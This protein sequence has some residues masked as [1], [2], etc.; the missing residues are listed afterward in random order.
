MDIKLVKRLCLGTVQFGLDYGIANQRGKISEG[1]VGQILTY[2]HQVGIDTIDTGQAYGDSEHVIGK[3]IEGGMCDFNIIT[4]TPSLNGF[5][6]E[7]NAKNIIQPSLKALGREKIYG[8]LV[9]QFSDYLTH[10]AL[11]GMMEELKR[12]GIVQKIGFSIYKPEELE[13]LFDRNVPFDIIQFPY[14]IFDRR[15]E[16]YFSRLKEKN[17]EINVRSVFLQ[18]L[19]F[20]NPDTL[21]EHLVHARD[22]LK[23]LIDASK[24]I[25]VPVHAVCLN[26]VLLNSDIDIAIIGIDSLE[27]LKQNIDAVKFLSEV[28][29]IYDDIKAISINDESILLPY[30]W[31]V[32]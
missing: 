8:Y 27:Q 1:E 18:G 25:N 16:Q 11:W 22:D 24:E 12:E 21:P 4:K 9:H 10:H 19:A 14:S 15:F 7:G 13:L 30:N 32:A 23:R 3:F 2:A 5:E 29:R 31:G 20:L 17:I 6:G 26:F 28:Q